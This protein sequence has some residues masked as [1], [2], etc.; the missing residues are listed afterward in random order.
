[1]LRLHEKWQV[2][3]EEALKE[4]EELCHLIGKFIVFNY[5]LYGHYPVTVLGDA[6]LKAACRIYGP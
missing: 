2:K 1:M 3:N 5:E 6:L 4:L